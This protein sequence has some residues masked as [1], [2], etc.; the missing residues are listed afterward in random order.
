[1]K[2]YSVSF[3]REVNERASKTGIRY[4]YGL[5]IDDAEKFIKENTGK[6]KFGFQ[7]KDSVT[8]EIIYKE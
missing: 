8:K 6:N 1:M 3:G 2:R 5:R 7:I 4:Q